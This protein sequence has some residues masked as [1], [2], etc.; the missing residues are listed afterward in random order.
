MGEE[1]ENIKDVSKK[2]FKQMEIDKIIEIRNK[3]DFNPLV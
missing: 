3:Y 1:I 2:L